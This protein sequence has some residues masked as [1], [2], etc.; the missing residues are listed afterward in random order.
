MA[1]IYTKEYKKLI[2][3]LKL[4]RIQAGLTQVEVSRSL[5]K[6]QSFVSKVELGERRLD[7]IEFQAILRLYNKKIV[8]L[9]GNK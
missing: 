6:P 1:S 5:N 8:D 4:A 9:L 3:E 7:P 2:Q